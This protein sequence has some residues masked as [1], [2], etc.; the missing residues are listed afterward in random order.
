MKR[1]KWLIV[2]VV[3]GLLAVV[4]AGAYTAVRLLAQSNQAETVAPRGARVMQSVVDNGSGP[5]S[6]QTTFLPAGELP[7]EPSAASGIVVSRRD[8]S[9]ML[10][11]GNIDVA[12]EVQVDP[13]TGLESRS[14]VPRTDGPQLEIVIGPDTV[15]YRDVTDFQ[16]DAPTES[17]ERVVQQIVRPA[18][19]AD[20]IEPQ[21]EMSV[22]G[23]RRGDR[24]IADVVVFGPL[25][26][27]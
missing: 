3:V 7:D 2:G 26:G 20:A 8:N 18:D 15:L 17:G 24:V 22:W 16:A 6:V 11:T 21:M 25:P 13:D 27:F 9:L 19:L 12:V 14:V 10:G 5:V 23:E 1:N 4:A